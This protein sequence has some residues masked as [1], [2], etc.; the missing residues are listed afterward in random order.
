MF[1]EVPKTY[2]DTFGSVRTEFK[3]HIHDSKPK[4]ELLAHSGFSLPTCSSNKNLSLKRR[5]I[6]MSVIFDPKK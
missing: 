2:L 6:I 1:S 4:I 5:D 3:A